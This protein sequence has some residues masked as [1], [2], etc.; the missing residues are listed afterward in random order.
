M[1]VKIMQRCV[2]NGGIYIQQ[3]PENVRFR[4][5]SVQLGLCI[6]SSLV[7]YTMEVKQEKSGV[8]FGFSKKS[9]TKRLKLAVDDA[10]LDDK[11]KRDFVSALENQEVKR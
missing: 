8:S 6:R 11:D 3:Q 7:V 1:A 9:E 4:Y 10:S 2:A 5:V